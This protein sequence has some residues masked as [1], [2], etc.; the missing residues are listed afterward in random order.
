VHHVKDRMKGTNRAF[1]KS[2]PQEQL[3][4]FAQ[5]RFR[6]GALRIFLGHFH[7][8]FHYRAARGRDLYTLPDWHSEGWISVLSG[9]RGGLRQGAWRDLLPV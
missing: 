9:E 5:N 2:L 8:S 4:Q 3:R 7:Q 1:R 6:E